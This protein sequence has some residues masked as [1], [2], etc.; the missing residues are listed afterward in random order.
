[1]KNIICDIDGVLMHD[2]TAVPGADGFIRRVLEQG[3]PLVLLT[4]YPSQTARDLHNRL[5]AAGIE[6]PEEKF[7]TSAMATADFLR[8]QDGTKAYVIGDGAL[9]HELYQA[10][11]T[12]TD[13]NPDFVIIGET[14]S[15]NWDMIHK[16]ARF[17][18]GGAR[19]IATNPDFNGPNQSPA[20]GALCAPI[21]RITGQQPFYV[22]KPSSWIIRSALNHIGA[23]SENTVIIGDNLRTDILAGFQ[24]GL[25]T[26]LVLSGVSTRDDI[27][28]MPFRPN[29]VFKSVAEIDVF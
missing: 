8:R 23:H 27:P 3:N 7:Y 21:E 2:N 22:G 4:N 28:K 29:H 9:T 13:I 5:A 17:V 10:G 12:I 24:A 16:A 1:M 19:F 26:I 15:Y 14:R 6:V 20:C 25:E 11:F 18:A